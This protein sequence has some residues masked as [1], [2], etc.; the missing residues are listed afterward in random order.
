MSASKKLAANARKEANKTVY[1]ARLVDNPTSPRK[2]RIMANVIRGKNVDY[3]MN[4]LKYSPREAS[5]KL[6]KLLKSA[7]A[8][9]QVKNEGMRL[10]NADLYVKTIMVD[11]G[12]MLKRIR[13]APQGRA[14]RIRKRSNHIT[15]VIAD[16]NTE[17]NNNEIIKEESQ[18]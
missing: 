16:R 15:L 10:E 5:E 1:M 8:N 9:W 7:I 14:N 13:T 4:V 6:L 2:T 18:N 11:G 3:A 17:N 12:R